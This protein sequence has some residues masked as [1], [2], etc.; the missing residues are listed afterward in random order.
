MLWTLMLLAVIATNG[1]PEPATSYHVTQVLSG[2]TIVVEGLGTVGYLGLIAPTDTPHPTPDTRLVPEPFAKESTA[3]NKELVEGKLVTLESIQPAKDAQGRT[4]AFVVVDGKSVGE[5]LVR[6]GLARVDTA[7]LPEGSRRDALLAA[8]TEAKAKKLGIWSTPAA[9]EPLVYA[10]KKGKSYHTATCKLIKAAKA[11]RITLA[12]AKKRGLAACKLCRP[13]LSSAE[14]DKQD[15][16][17]TVYITKHG[18][19]FHRQGCIHLGKS[20][21]PIARADAVKRGYTPCAVCKP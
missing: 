11:E 18:K 16:P 13:D 20:S 19:K 1:T 5:E 15:H 14:R 10:T 6:R 9:A 21:K 17:E 2:D 7:G 4:L 8:Q 12:E 3:A